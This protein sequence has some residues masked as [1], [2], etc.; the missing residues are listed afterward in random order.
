MR[1][2]ASSTALLALVAVAACAT[3]AP[4]TRRNQSVLTRKEIE[5]A[6]QLTAMELI[7]AQRPFWL[8]MRGNKSFTTAPHIP[9]YIDGVRAGE[10]DMLRQI[11]TQDIEEIRHYDARQA[12][13]KFGTGHEYGAIEITMKG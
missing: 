5:D 6:P 1:R 10:V 12:Q 8:Q 13:F 3:A 9:V 7:Q 2:R 4:G 11:S